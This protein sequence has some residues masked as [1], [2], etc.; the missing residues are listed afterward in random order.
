MHFV[1]VD[2]GMLIH[3]RVAA[4]YSP[5][6]DAVCVALPRIWLN[7]ELF[8]A[9]TFWRA[10]GRVRSGRIASLHE[11]FPTY[12][13][14]TPWEKRGDIAQAL[15]P[16]LP[17]LIVRSEKAN[18][19]IGVVLVDADGAWRGEY[20]FLQRYRSG[21]LYLYAG[22]AR[23]RK[24]QRGLWGWLAPFDGRDIAACERQ[25]KKLLAQ[26][27]AL[28]K[29]FKPI[30]PPVPPSWLEV[31]PDFPAELRRKRPVDDINDAI[32]YTVNEHIHSPYGIMLARKVGSDVLIR[33][34]FKWG[35]A[36]NWSRYSRFVDEAHKLGALFG[37]GTTCSA[38]YHGENGLSEKEVI[39]MATRNP[40]GRLVD[41]WG[42]PNCRHGTLSNPR[43]V[44]YILNWCFKQIDA[45]ADYLFMDEINAALRE[46]EGYDDYSIRDFREYLLRKYCEGEGWRKDDARWVKRFGVDFNDRR[47]CPDGTMATF[48]YRAYLQN[49]GFADRP[50]S[51]RNPFRDDWTRFRHER[52]LRAW[53]RMTDEIREYARKKG[54]RVFISANGL[55]KFVDLQVLGVWGLWRLKDGSVDLS[56]S[57]VR[58]WWDTIRQ[59][60]FI[61]GRKVPV[62]FFHDW[63]F[64]GFPWMRVSPSDRE[65]WMRVRGAE[66]YAA[67]GFFAFPILGPFGCDALRD[68]TIREVARQT[69]FYQRHRDL[70]LKAMPI[71]FDAVKTDAPLLSTAL[72]IRRKPPALLVHIINRKTVNWQ[73]QKRHDIAL[74]IPTPVLPKRTTVVSPDDV[75]KGVQVERIGEQ[76]R[77]RLTELV[78]YSVIVL[79]YSELPQWSSDFAPHIIPT[80]RWERALQNTFLVHRGGIVDDG[81]KLVAFL[82]GKLHP[83]LRNPPTFIVNAPNG[84]TL[85]VFVQGVAQ[86]GARL[87]LLV[88]G[89]PTQTYDLPD[90]DGKNDGDA[91]E[92]ARAFAFRI[93]RGKHRITL[94][95]IGGDWA[96]IRWYA[97]KGMFE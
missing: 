25:V 39:D 91:P 78:A 34:W 23:A 79:E 52:D 14:V 83:Y 72:W 12:A 95:N 54:R 77:L 61:A 90:R 70:Y 30:A 16:K 3:F 64:G 84:G 74:E 28:I 6:E 13:G 27:D 75:S 73:L 45:G 29:S 69:A 55:A 18:V 22:Y 59:G 41:A 49:R 7:E 15:S 8:D 85:Q 32:V 92:Y 51:R 20:S 67:G 65:L 40:Y 48:N 81:W 35:N 33:A 19:G 10:D 42:V 66:I 36:P 21:V 38:L 60:W 44:N 68:G 9:Y 89:V 24:A 56:Q 11:P 76:L 71:S 57:Q 46:N 2:D 17:A 58:D 47:M 43:Y 5:P 86:L 87:Q 53:K 63:G 31:P 62:V 88:D 94:D 50:L 97:F 80:K 82:Q 96:C 1:C 26:T 4:R 37:G 93:P